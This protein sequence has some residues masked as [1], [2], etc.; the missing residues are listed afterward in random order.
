MSRM[1]QPEFRARSVRMVST[2]LESDPA[3]TEMAAIRQ[4]A[5]RQ[6]VAAETLRRWLRKAQIDTGQRKGRSAEE[7]VEIKKLKKRVVE[8]ERTN[9]LLKQASAFFA[10]ELDRPATR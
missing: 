3:L 6:Q 8:L 2:V 7:S 4:V 9:E 1:Y 10:A 5:S